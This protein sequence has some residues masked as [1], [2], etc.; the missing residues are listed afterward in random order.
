MPPIPW[1]DDG[2]AATGHRQ[3]IPGI[4]GP[5]AGPYSAWLRSPDVL[6]GRKIVG[7]YLLGYQGALSPKLTESPSS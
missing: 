3:V 5:I 1:T 6:I 2:R 7:D 4:R